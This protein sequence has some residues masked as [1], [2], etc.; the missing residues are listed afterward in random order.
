[1][2]G[3]A[4]F[5]G[6]NTT[7]RELIIR[8]MMHSQKHRGPD[9]EGVFFQDD[10]T[11]GFVR[12]SVLDLQFGHQPMHSSDG[13]YSIIYNGEIYNYIELRQRLI[14]L[15]VQ[16]KTFSDTEVL[17][18][19]YIHFGKAVLDMLNG[20]F[21]FAVYDAEDASL[22]IARD[23]FGIKPLYYFTTSDCFIFSSEI[24]ALF[25]HPAVTSS[26]NIPALQEY[27]TFQLILGDET[28]FQHIKKLE[29]AHYMIVR[30]GKVIEHEEYWKLK[31]QIDDSKSLDQ[32]TDELLVLFE[33]AL[34]LQVRS[35]V[36]VGAHLSGGLDSSTVAVL[37]SKNYF[38]KLKTFTGGFKDGDAYDESGY[39]SIVSE[40]I[41][42]DHYSVFPSAQDFIDNIHTLVYHMDEPGAGPGIF[43]QYMISK[44]ASE[45]VK[46]VLGGQ[47]ADEVF[48]GYARYAVA[49]LE[50]CLKGEI[51]ETREEGKHIVSL[52]S[53]IPN[54][55]ML[56]QYI[57]LIKNQFSH[58]LFD[59]MDQRYY[60]LVDRSPNLKL[61]YSKE[62]VESRD[63]DRIQHKFQAIFNAPESK[64]YFNKMT[65]FDLKTLLPTLLQIEDRVSMAVS[66]E[67]RVPFL[68]R[69][70]VELAASIP[71]TMKFSEGKTKFVMLQ[72][73]KNILPKE[74]VNR[75][76]KMGFPV[77]I[78]E[79]MAGP[80]KEFILD[81]FRSRKTIERGIFNIGNIVDHVIR[82]GNFNR[83]IWGALNIELW[84][85]QF[86]DP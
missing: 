9:D 70:I 38:G 26:V 80:L 86:I 10:T 40:Y 4:G 18:Y 73:V 13:R 85:R 84:H 46:V 6:G 54:L 39:A 12:L 23:Q 3:I 36:P 28:L 66:L 45:H 72:A 48:G 79:W 22:F 42:S 11:L 29:P 43:P 33:S 8:D 62:L 57:P 64:S 37:A 76:D 53:I 14:S 25:K 78:N 41:N 55:P 63:E 65:Y 47:G 75:K 67:S 7:N 82:Q 20:M 51:L 24:K 71:P 17:L 1:M 16:L 77:P 58:G 2:C 69:R 30:K 19:S 74:I 52:Q 27:L 59:S 5:Q 31:Y 68:D 81:I 35:D 56:K 21:A 32:F 34:S 61:L 50:Q 44:L 83:D 49:Y 60:R 15:G